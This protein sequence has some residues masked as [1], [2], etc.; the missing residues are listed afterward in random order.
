MTQRQRLEA[1]ETQFNAQMG[2]V[3]ADL[4]R[5][6][7]ADGLVAK[8]ERERDRETTLLQM[9]VGAADTR[10]VDGRE[11]RAGTDLGLGQQAVIGPAPRFVPSATAHAFR[12]LAPASDEQLIPAST[13]GNPSRRIYTGATIKF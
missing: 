12:L 2:V 11:D 9:H 5:A 3:Q 4:R 7:P 8:D 1:R 10:T 13:Q 6:Y